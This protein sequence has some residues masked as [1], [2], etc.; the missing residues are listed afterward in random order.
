[1]LESNEPRRRASGLPEILKVIAASG[2]SR[3][4]VDG[5]RMSSL[6]RLQMQPLARSPAF[7][8]VGQATPE[9]AGAVVALPRKWLEAVQKRGSP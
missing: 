2:S 1:M 3:E 4:L 8:A 5:E 7:E 6:L 9:V